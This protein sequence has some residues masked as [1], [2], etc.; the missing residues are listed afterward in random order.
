MLEKLLAEAERTTLNTLSPAEQGDYPDEHHPLRRNAAAP[1]PILGQVL[2][3]PVP[4]A[5]C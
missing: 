3:G 1:R 2:R 5:K 4:R